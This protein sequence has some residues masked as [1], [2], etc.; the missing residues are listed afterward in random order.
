MGR[1]FAQLA[2]LEKVEDQQTKT[3][4]ERQRSPRSA[5]EPVES[6]PESPILS[7]V[8]DTGYDAEG[9]WELLKHNIPGYAAV[10][11][12]RYRARQQEYLREERRQGLIEIEKILKA[13]DSV[14]EPVSGSS[15]PSVESPVS[16]PPVPLPG[17]QAVQENNARRQHK[18]RSDAPRD[19]GQG[20]LFSQA[21]P[22]LSKSV[23][24]EI[25]QINNLL[26]N[27]EEM[28]M[29]SSRPPWRQSR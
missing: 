5:S 13:G 3:T 9:Q 19:D 20:D 25:T 6:L 15:P 27:E 7:E 11:E 28:T 17:N 14:D 21:F 23:I 16:V 29:T 24:K 18:R 1:A 8:L 26:R 4:D 2:E 10:S 12:S 22:E